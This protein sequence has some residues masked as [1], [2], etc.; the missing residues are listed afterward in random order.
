MKLLNNKLDFN[1]TAQGQLPAADWNELA[2]EIQNLIT[3]PNGGN[4]SLNGSNAFQVMTAVRTIANRF[5]NESG[6]GGFTDI[7]PITSTGTNPCDL[8]TQTGF[9][10]TQGNAGT[11]HTLPSEYSSGTNYVLQHLKGR[12]T[13]LAIQFLFENSLSTERYART[14][15]R[16]KQAGSWG[17]WVRNDIGLT[18]W[19][20]QTI[21]SAIADCNEV[22]RSGAYR[23]NGSTANTPVATRF[24]TLIHQ[25]GGDTITLS[26]LAQVATQIAID[27]NNAGEMYLRQRT[28]G[29]GWGAWRQLSTGAFAL[30]DNI[31]GAVPTW[32]SNSTITMGAGL[33]C[34]DSTKSSRI[35]IPNATVINFATTGLNAL[36]TGS[37]ASNTWYYIWALLNTSTNAVGYVVSTSN[38]S[39]TMPTGFTTNTV[40]RLLQYQ[41]KTAS[42]GS[43]IQPFRFFDDGQSLR[44]EWTTG[45]AD[46]I[47]FNQVIGSATPFVVDSSSS[48]PPICNGLNA[49]LIANVFQDTTSSG[50]WSRLSTDAGT[51]N[52]WI[53]LTAQN[54]VAEAEYEIDLYDATRQFRLRNDAGGGGAAACSCIITT[55]G[56]IFFYKGVI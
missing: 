48:V 4:T 50:L 42:G 34:A 26:P 1:T 56:Y 14:W 29:G 23:C 24:Y 11:N 16:A 6:L 39:P 17:A 38:T 27:T 12:T 36:D 13:D 40:R 44:C 19:G 35:T 55:L 43:N 25:A 54:W 30:G 3:E 21:S 33:D 8:I 52:N 15:Y 7:L 49:K 45:R 28:T 5:L 22:T 47:I 2:T 20:I 51:A 9:F 46:G 32:T 37:V 41:F 10:A 53:T 18:G 31:R